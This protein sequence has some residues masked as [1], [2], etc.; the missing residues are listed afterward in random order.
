VITRAPEAF[1]AAA[2]RTP[3]DRLATARE[4]LL[5]RPDGFR[6]SAET[7]TDNAYMRPA[8][9]VDP[10]R[11]LAEHRALVAAIRARAGLA[12]TV[13]D[14]DPATPDAVFPN[15]VFATVPGRLV[16]GAMRHPERQRESRRADIPAWFATRGCAVE[17]LDAEAGVVAELT[18]SLVIDR[19][20]GLGFIGLSERCNEA[21][22]RAMHRAFDLRAS[23]VFDLSP[24]EYHTNVVLAVLAG[25]AALVCREAIADPAA[26]DAIVALYGD[27][28]VPITVAEKAAFVGNAIALRPDQVWMSATAERGLAAAT[29][30][31]LRALG[32]VLHTV[33]LAEIEKAGGSL[34]CC[35]ADLY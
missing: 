13:F 5:V 28:A 34:R 26:A 35:I 24:G 22:A 20:R 23:L 8:L 16:I 33:E 30:E 3:A 9:A 17:R 27:G 11:A 1:L 19:A 32:F 14:G 18:G 4:V 25:R 6:L 29:R 15:N 12:V 2:R 7:A 21:G 31:R 10:E